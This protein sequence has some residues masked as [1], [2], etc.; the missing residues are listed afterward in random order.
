MASP[1]ILTLTSEA[2]S[3]LVHFYTEQNYKVLPSPKAETQWDSQ[4]PV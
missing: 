3:L 2:F 1:L 4:P